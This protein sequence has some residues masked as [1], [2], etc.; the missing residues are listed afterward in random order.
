M[1]ARPKGTEELTGEQDGDEEAGGA[2]RVHVDGGT[3]ESEQRLRRDGQRAG[4]PHRP[5]ADEG[6]GHHHQGDEGTDRRQLRR[7]EVD[8]G[9]QPRGVGANRERLDGEDRLQHAGVAADVVLLEGRN[10]KQLA[11]KSSGIHGAS[12][13]FTRRSSSRP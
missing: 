10:R 12:S 7:M 3:S 4:D 9:D 5:A 11:A 8:G 13:S 1:A 6:E 2:A